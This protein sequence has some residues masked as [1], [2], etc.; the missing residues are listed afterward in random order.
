[1]SL[2]NIADEI[3]H[4]ITNTLITH[5]EEFGIAFSGGIDSTVL[6]KICE[7][8]LKNRFVLLTI[9]FPNSNDIEFAKKIATQLDQIEHKIFEINNQRFIDDLKYIL[10]YN[11]CNNISHIENCLAFYYISILAKKNNIKLVIT[12]NGLDEL[13]CGYDIFRRIYNR[14]IEEIQMMIEKKLKNEYV[15]MQEINYI[16]NKLGIQIK[17][18][19]LSKNFVRFAKKIP[20]DKKILSSQDY[21]R[22]HI[23]REFAVSINV[24]TE[25]A[26]RPKKALQYG[27]EIHKNLL[28]ILKNPEIKS[29]VEGKK[30]HQN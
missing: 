8:K 5:N 23:L 6:A 24:P 25:S 10:E 3:D 17:Q 2:S 19:F 4:S 11:Q 18:P 27:S 7:K 16:T 22:K 28:K 15:L 29:I 12:A 1:M 21:L 20:I 30:P 26:L 14:G 13:F 9:G